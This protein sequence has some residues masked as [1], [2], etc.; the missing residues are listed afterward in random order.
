MVVLDRICGAA[1]REAFVGLTDVI[2]KTIALFIPDIWPLTYLE[3]AFNSAFDSVQ[4]QMKPL[5][6]DVGAN[7]G[8][9]MEAQMQAWLKTQKD[10]LVAEIQKQ[11]AKL[12]EVN[13]EVTA[14]LNRLNDLT[15]RVNAIEEQLRSKSTSSLMSV[16]G[17]FTK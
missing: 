2:Q 14:Q 10:L 17:G 15:A 13:A 1:Y 3:S 9:N 8:R 5:A 7:M 12:Q 16:F 4:T 11:Y 6:Y